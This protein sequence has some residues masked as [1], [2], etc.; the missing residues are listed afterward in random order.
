MKLK[1]E[2][3]KDEKNIKNKYINNTNNNLEYE[4]NLN[5][6]NSNNKNSYYKTK[7][8]LLKNNINTNLFISYLIIITSFQTF[9]Y[10]Y[11]YIYTKTSGNVTLQDMGDKYY[12]GQSTC[13]SYYRFSK[14]GINFFNCTVNSNKNVRIAF[15]NNKYNY[16]QILKIQVRCLKIV[17]L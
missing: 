11:I 8:L 13:S 12:S 2:I 4:T 7:T 10:D 3:F 6:N 16:T 5:N 14:S 9:T 1:K 15:V 17:F